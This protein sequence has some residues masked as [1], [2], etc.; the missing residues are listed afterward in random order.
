M[1]IL[2]IEHS[3][4]NFDAWKQAFEK[5]PLNRKASGVLSYKIMQPADNEKYLIIWLEF[6]NLVDAEAMNKKLSNF[7][8]NVE[9]SIMMNPKTQILNIVEI[10]AL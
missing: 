7:F 1:V 8:K 10:K 2:Q 5:D 9:T 6:D 4:Q 3:I